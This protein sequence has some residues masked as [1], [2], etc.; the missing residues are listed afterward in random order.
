MKNTKTNVNYENNCNDE[1]NDEKNHLSLQVNSQL[2]GISKQIS[3]GD[4]GTQIEQDGRMEEVTT[5]LRSCCETFHTISSR[6]ESSLSEQEIESHSAELY[7]K[8]NNIWIPINEVF[9]L[10]VQGQSGNENDTYFSSDGYVYKVNN[11]MNSGSI[12]S[13]FERLSLHNSI[14]PETAY[15]LVGFTGF[16]GRNIFPILKQRVVNHP[17]IATPS[18][19]ENYMISLGFIKVNNSTYK[20]KNIIISDLQSRNVLKDDDGDIYV[21]D[22]EFEII[23]I[24][25]VLE[26]S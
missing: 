11:L 17:T 21:V 13:L 15:T 18:E 3:Q 4:N 2:Y 5:R 10:G 26:S 24:D 8:E 9:D 19:I 7:A 6:G 20:N 16:E 14:F 12:I 1:I 23:C 25:N 22:A